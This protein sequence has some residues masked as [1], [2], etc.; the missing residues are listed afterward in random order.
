[1]ESPPDAGR[2]AENWIERMFPAVSFGRISVNHLVDVIQSIKELDNAKL[3]IVSI[4]LR[5]EGE[6]KLRHPTSKNWEGHAPFN[7]D[8]VLA[9]ALQLNR[10]VDEI[11]FV[12][13]LDKE[14]IFE[15]TLSRSG[16]F[17][18]Y[19]GN[20]SGFSEFLRVA[21]SRV[22]T[23]AQEELKEFKG[24]ESRPETG[25]EVSTLSYQTE[26]GDRIDQEVDNL[27]RSLIKNSSYAV[28]LNHSGN[29]WFSISAVD[30]DDGSGY[31]LNLFKHRLDI[32]FSTRAEPESV[33]RLTSIIDGVL[34]K[35]KRGAPE[36]S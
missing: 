1:M 11:R 27:T 25:Y 20:S 6:S 35:A 13:S 24:L 7:K 15:C 3:D 5:K 12:L 34:P 36:V 2:I 23:H 19:G 22:V 17:V 26:E 21:V 29:P 16:H 30:R 10:V 31:E 33:S 32:V 9:T 8:N 14:R 28:S 18:F 4:I